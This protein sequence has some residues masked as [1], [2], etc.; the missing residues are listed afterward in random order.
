MKIKVNQDLKDAFGKTIPNGEKP[1][2][3]LVDVCISSILSPIQGD[4]EKSKMLK[5]D[6]FKKL[7]D[8]KAEVDLTAEEIALIKKC[9]AHFQPQLIMGQC[10]EMIEEGKVK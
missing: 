1:K 5:Y 8:G 7:R 10:F 4:D 3:L 2:L 6:I 9:I